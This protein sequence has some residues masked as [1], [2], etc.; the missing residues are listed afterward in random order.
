MQA[1]NP[2]NKIKTKKPIAIFYPTENLNKNVR[3]LFKLKA[4][5]KVN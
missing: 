1:V 5:I 4:E 3:E 2:I